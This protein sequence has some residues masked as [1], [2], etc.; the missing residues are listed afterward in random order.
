MTEEQKRSNFTRIA[1]KR[2]QRV[3]D[4]VNHLEECSDRRRYEFDED[5]VNYMFEEINKALNES[6]AVFMKELK[7]E[8]NTKTEFKFRK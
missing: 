6:K 7:N 2:V 8:G 4:F 3:I 1:A 5:D